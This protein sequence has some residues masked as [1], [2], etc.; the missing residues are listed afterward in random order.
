MAPL[1]CGDLCELVAPESQGQSHK[2]IPSMVRELS[3][4]FVETTIFRPRLLGYWDFGLLWYLVSH[5]LF[6]KVLN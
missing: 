4:I 3:A 6:R 1:N 5:T 2:T